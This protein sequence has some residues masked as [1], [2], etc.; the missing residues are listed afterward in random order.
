MLN[1]QYYNKENLYCD[2]VNAILRVAYDLKPAC[3]TS[4]KA[5]YPCLFRIEYNNYFYY[6]KRLSL[7]YFF[8]KSV[9]FDFNVDEIVIKRAV[10]LY[11]NLKDDYPAVAL[12]KLAKMPKK[13][14]LFPY[15][16]INNASRPE[17]SLLEGLAFGYP[18]NDIEW[19]VNRQL[20]PMQKFIFFC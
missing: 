1:H 13:D 9:L 20:L 8:D 11:E 3:S 19:Y 17:V 6:S 12:V 15:A 10:V 14:E 4:I 2:D 7:S 16:C 5:D 18:L